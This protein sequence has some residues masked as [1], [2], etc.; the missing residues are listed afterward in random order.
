MHPLGRYMRGL[1]PLVLA[2][3]AVPAASGAVVDLTAGTGT[4]GAL[5]GAHFVWGSVGG[6]TGNIS[7]FLRVQKNGLSSGYNTSASSPPF[8]AKNGSFT[9]DL[10][11]NEIQ[12]TVRGGVNYLT[13]LLDIN[14]NSGGGNEFLSLDEVKIFTTTVAS[15]TT[16]N[17]ASLGTLRYDMDAAPAGNSEVLLDYSKATGSGTTD[18]TML[19][20]AA[21]FAGS[22]PTDY[23]VLFSAFGAKTNAP[24]RTWDGSAGFEEWAVP[25]NP[26]VV[27]VP[28]PA[29]AA[30]MLP[31]GLLLVRR[32]RVA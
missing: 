8:D 13:F 4:E 29:T 10:R 12:I 14:E 7:S 1:S 31:A 27:Y 19:I 23:V 2:L 21:N 9:R 17:I 18:M 28:E 24:G 16:T 22:A 15:Q 5:N 30:A 3:A 32:R 6:G 11:L 26:T 20:P 25:G